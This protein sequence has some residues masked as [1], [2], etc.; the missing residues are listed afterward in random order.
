MDEAEVKAIYAEMEQAAELGQAD[1]LQLLFDKYPNFL[2]EGSEGHG[3]L[4]AIHMCATLG[5]LETFKVFIECYP[6]TKDWGLGHLG[7][8]LGS[9]I[10]RNDIPFVKYLLDEMGMKVNEGCIM[11]RPVIQLDLPISGLIF[12]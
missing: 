6:Q 11:N 5:G 12:N 10:L 8:T 9:A 1:K 3:G 2:G 4:G 7:N